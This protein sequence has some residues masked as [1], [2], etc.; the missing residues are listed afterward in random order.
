MKIFLSVGYEFDECN[1]NIAVNDAIHPPSIDIRAFT[2][3]SMK[4]QPSN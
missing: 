4:T 2:G 3:I 1:V